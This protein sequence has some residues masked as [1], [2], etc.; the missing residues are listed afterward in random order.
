KL[1]IYYG[2]AIAAVFFL[3]QRYLP[4]ISFG[5]EL[6]L[7]AANLGFRAVANNPRL[8]LRLRERRKVAANTEAFVFESEKQLVF[9]AGQFLEWTLAHPHPDNRGIRR[10]FTIASSPTEPE[11]MLAT[12]FAPQSSSFKKALQ[13]LKPE[14]EVVVSNREG[15]F[16]MPSKA[17][18]PLVF[19]AG[20][21]GITPFRSMIKYLLDTNLKDFKISLLYSNKTEQDIAFRDLFDEAQRKLGVKTVY[22]ITENTSDQWLG[23]TGFID[24]AMIKSEVTDWQS[25]IFYVSG[26]E[27]M[28][29]AF[30]KMLAGMGVRRSNI[31]RDYF[32]GY[33]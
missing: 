29:K 21:I 27:P 23:R 33:E 20:G 4:Q 26:P 12:K 7:L 5:F 19:I 25:S 14:D 16:T 32:P 6:S 30:E 2:I 15:E 28:V 1:R 31:K 3:F 11:I 22:T 10:Y 17:S 8:V 13:A 9:K 24:E 18:Q